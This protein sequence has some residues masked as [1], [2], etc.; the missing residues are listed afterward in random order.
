MGKKRVSVV[1]VRLA[2]VAYSDHL[3]NHGSVDV[4]ENVN[5]EGFLTLVHGDTESY[6]IELTWSQWKSLKLSVKAIQKGAKKANKKAEEKY[7]SDLTDSKTNDEDRDVKKKKNKS[8][9]K[10]VEK[11]SPEL[12]KA[13]G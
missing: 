8:E 2:S 12:D 4:T 9:Q 5:G 7:K 6:A 13:N 11:P 10:T 3:H 1:K